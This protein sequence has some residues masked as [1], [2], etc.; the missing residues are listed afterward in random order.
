MSDRR[1]A[2]VISRGRTLRLEGVTAILL[3]HSPLVGPTSLQPLADALVSRGHVAIVPDVRGASTWEALASAAVSEAQALGVA[4]DAVMGH[5]GAGAVLPIVGAALGARRIVFIDAVVPPESGNWTQ[6]D[7]MR[8]RLNTMAGADRLLPVWPD[9]WNPNM[10]RRLVP[11]DS[12]RSAIALECRPVSLDLYD[13]EAAQPDGWSSAESCVYIQLSSA[14]IDEASEAQARAW[15][16]FSNEGHHLDTATRPELVADL[17][18]QALVARRVRVGDIDS[19]RRRG[20]VTVPRSAPSLLVVAPADSG[21][22]AVINEC[23][24]Q[25]AEL[26]AGYV[27]TSAGRTWIECPLHSWRF[28]LATGERLIRNEVS[29][30]PMD[31]LRTFACDVDRHGMIW[32]DTPVA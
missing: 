5:S 2:D 16:V 27:S 32:V 13:S 23:A 6:T 31:C 18:E 24:H 3:L 14:Y 8:S 28:D 26:L 25:G 20:G 12:L 19:L 15:P 30:D 1:V 22:Y 4:P 17:V 9:W 10:M 29:P 21:P 11:D 7:V